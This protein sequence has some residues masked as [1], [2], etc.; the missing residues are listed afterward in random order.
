M[1]LVKYFLQFGFPKLKHSS[2]LILFLYIRFYLY[3]V[4][5]V[6]ANCSLIDRNFGWQCLPSP[7]WCPS[8][9]QPMCR[10]I[11]LYSLCQFSHPKKYQRKCQMFASGL[12]T[13][14]N[15]LVTVTALINF[16]DIHKNQIL[17]L[18]YLSSPISTHHMIN[19]HSYQIMENIS[20]CHHSFNSP[21]C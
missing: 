13:L 6:G 8:R 2:K 4:N 11:P 10:N 1:L 17:I 19:I 5:I 7:P 16:E 14:C 18:F 20:T 21:T 12:L 3:F 15:S 9:I